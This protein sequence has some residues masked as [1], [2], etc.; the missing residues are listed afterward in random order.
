MSSAA[1]DSTGWAGYF[2][3]TSD[4]TLVDEVTGDLMYDLSNAPALFW[5][6]LLAI[7]DT[8][9]ASIRVVNAV[10]D[11]AYSFEIGADFDTAAE[12]GTLF[13]DCSDD[14]SMS[15]DTTWRIYAGNG[16]A[17]MP[18]ASDTLGSENVWDSDYWAV[19]HMAQDPTTSI[20]DSTSN[21]RRLTSYGSMTTGDL[22]D[23]PFGK[24]I[25]FDGTDDRL[26]ISSGPSGVPWSVMAWLKTRDATKFQTFAQRVK[27]NQDWRW[28]AANTNG[29]GQVAAQ[30]VTPST[31]QAISTGSLATD[32]W[33]FA[34]ASFESPSKR[35]A[36]V[37]D[38]AYVLQSSSASAFVANEFNVGARYRRDSSTFAP[39][40]DG[41]IG[42]MRVLSAHKSENWRDT[43]YNNQNAPGS[44]WTTGAWVTSEPATPASATDTHAGDPT[45]LLVIYNADIPDSVLWATD[46]AERRNVPL[47]NRVGISLAPDEVVSEAAFDTLVAAI[48]S[49][50]VANG[51]EDGIT[52]ILCGYGV[53]GGVLRP[54]GLIDPLAARLQRMD[55]STVETTN[56]LHSPD[57]RTIARPNLSNL[58][59]DR[60]VARIDAPTLADA[61]AILDRAEAIEAAAL[62]GNADGGG[63]IYLDPYPPAGSV[64]ELRRDQMTDWA[65]G[66]DRQR[67]RLPIHLPS[68]PGGGSEPQFNAIENDG[69]FWGWIQSTPPTDF[70][71]ASAGRRAFA[72]QLS[73]DHVTAPTLR[74]S[75]DD[76]WASR[77]FA[78]G[79]AAAAGSTR[80]FTPTAVPRVE[81]F[82]EAL[83]LGWTLGEAWHVA[84]PLLRS[85]LVLVGD[86]LMTVATPEAG[87][88]LFGPFD[89]LDDASFVSPAA[90]L[91]DDERAVLLPTTVQL[92]ETQRG[93][94]V[95]RHVD[96]VGR[97]EAGLRHVHLQSVGDDWH[98]VPPAP[99]WPTSPG[100]RLRRVDS[101]WIV[102]AAW[103]STFRSLEIESVE[104]EQRIADDP[105]SV[106]DEQAASP[107]ASRVVFAAAAPAA[108]VRY[109]VVAVSPDGVRTPGPWSQIA[110]SSSAETFQLPLL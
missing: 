55:G 107:S 70:F 80:V 89:A 60:V 2:E 43:H 1:F 5:A 77:S 57:P 46:Y 78:A 27:D 21:D 95:L 40:W 49:H 86:P 99:A 67:L 36:A 8:A 82:F 88:D 97:T 101:E 72:V 83:R 48:D 98:A 110:T 14:L 105:V 74:D 53:P 15:S 28:N 30:S 65:I 44:F 38:D 32:T 84:S 24:A 6:A 33:G 104:L 23:G 66:L 20:L 71:G 85:G 7:A 58:T 94:Y 102:L 91:R 52:T 100:Y 34:Y 42:E 106:V 19:W 26:Q 51:L 29:F 93:V 64:Y 61:I 76:S 90:M 25:D 75:N 22:V 18:E 54:D 109:R 69:F 62:S 12:I 103:A 41:A 39:Y 73:P 56:P 11:R 79:Y 47:V 31:V 68:D 50:L 108:P 9:G 63:A 16:A 4:N 17:T 35:H 87:W 37:A 10:G 45:S 59:G 13:F 3:I 96:A 81:P 92:A